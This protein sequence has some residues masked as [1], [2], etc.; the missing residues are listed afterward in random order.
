M[1]AR[2]KK[3]E[4]VTDESYTKLEMYCIWL[5]EY[6][7]ALIRAGFKSDIAMTFVIDKGSY[8]EWCEYKTIN[9]NDYLDGEDD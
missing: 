7:T 9:V 5:H 6:Y 1:A 4:T 2:R 8:P 3:V